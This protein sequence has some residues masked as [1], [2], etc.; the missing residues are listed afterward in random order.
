M[1]QVYLLNERYGTELGEARLFYTKKE[2]EDYIKQAISEDVKDDFFYNLK[3]EGI[4]QN[5]IDAVIAWGKDKGYCDDYI[6]MYSSDCHEFSLT[7]CELDLD[8]L[9]DA[10][11]TDETIDIDDEM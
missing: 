1:S 3:E 8:R 6:Y 2:G 10:K 7:P 11:E 5:D 4:D 9:K